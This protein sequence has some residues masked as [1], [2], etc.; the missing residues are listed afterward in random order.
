M[1]QG[2]WSLLVMGSH[3]KFLRSGVMGL[4]VCSDWQV[5]SHGSVGTAIS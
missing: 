2:G 3:R 4:E 5:T 1:I